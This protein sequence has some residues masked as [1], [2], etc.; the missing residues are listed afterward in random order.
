[1]WLGKARQGVA[2]K[3]KARRGKEIENKAWQGKAR[4]G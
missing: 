4:L 3:F 2:R 1:L